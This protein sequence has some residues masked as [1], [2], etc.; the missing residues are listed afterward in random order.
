MKKVCLIVLAVAGLV[1]AP[2][3]R[4]LQT[5][6]VLD[7]IAMPIAVAAVSEVT[8]VPQD[9]LID[10]VVAMNAVDVAP[11]EFVEV[12]RYSPVLLV[13]PVTG[14]EV[15]TFVTNEVDRGITDRELVLALRDRIRS[16]G[17]DQFEVV[18]DRRVILDRRT[19]VPDVVVRRAD[20]LRRNHPHGGPPGQIKKEIGVQTGAEVVHGT[21]PGNSPSRTPVT[22][23]SSRDDR[24]SPANDS[25]NG[26]PPHAK[27]KGNDHPSDAK[28]HPGKG[29]KGKPD[30][31]KDDHPGK[32]NNLGD[33]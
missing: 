19:V 31:G 18:E 15:V 12:V 10:L 1:M 16:T 8:G 13:D 3:A 6:E 23:D 24:P 33:R 11:T 9:S 22:R 29:N 21:K 30:K 27:N 25:R 7:M 2:A 14:P 5:E 17:I 28:D 26:P 4:A 32:G 20:E